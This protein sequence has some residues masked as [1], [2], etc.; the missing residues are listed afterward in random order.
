MI[1]YLGDLSAIST[2]S[3]VIRRSDHFVVKHPVYSIPRSLLRH[4]SSPIVPVPRC[5]N[6]IDR[7]IPLP[8]P[9]PPYEIIPPRRH[10][11][12]L[13][14]LPRHNPSNLRPR[15]RLRPSDDL[16]SRPWHVVT[17]GCVSG[18]QQSRGGGCGPSPTL[19]SP[20]IGIR[21]I[22]CEGSPVQLTRGDY[23]PMGIEGEGR[24]TAR[25]GGGS[26][27]C[28]RATRWCGAMGR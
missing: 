4:P 15:P 2:T 24:G 5:P 13:Y 10:T 7:I 26:M 8:P 3:A 20:L 27:G 28:E 14:P 1:T 21:G 18:S 6:A 12:L 25:P 9:S 23:P 16:G 19:K 11:E 22:E 17:K